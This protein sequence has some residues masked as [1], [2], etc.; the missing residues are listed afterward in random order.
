MAQNFKYIFY[1]EGGKM[2]WRGM[3]ILS[4]FWGGGKQNWTRFGGS[5]LCNFGSCLKFNVQNTEWG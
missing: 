5:F 2:I 4:I 1:G 3:K